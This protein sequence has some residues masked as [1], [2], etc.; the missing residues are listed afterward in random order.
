MRRLGQYILNI[1]I[2]IDQLANA[3]FGGCPDTTISA[4]LWQEYPNS[5][6]RKLVDIFFGKDHCKRVATNGDS[7][8]AIIRRT[9]G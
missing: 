6:L 8:T 7:G 3:I 2:A 1:F 4:R 9:N 5:E